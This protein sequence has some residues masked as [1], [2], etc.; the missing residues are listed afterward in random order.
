MEDDTG[1][2]TKTQTVDSSAVPTKSKESHIA[3]VSVRSIITMGVVAT[4]CYMAVRALKV[5]EPLYS[6]AFLCLGYYFGQGRSLPS[7]T[8][9]ITSTTATQKTV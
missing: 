1:T 4:V 6:M 8:G 5:E 2:I 7:Q 9:M 3:S